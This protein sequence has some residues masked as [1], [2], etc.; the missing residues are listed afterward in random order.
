MFTFGNNGRFQ[1]LFRESV[2]FSN[3]EKKICL[4]YLSSKISY[5][6]KILA[7]Y[8]L[9]GWSYWRHVQNI[10]TNAKRR[11]LEI[12]AEYKFLTSNN[13]RIQFCRNS[14]VLYFLGIKSKIYQC[15]AQSELYGKVFPRSFQGHSFQKRFL[16]G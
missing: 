6:P 2:T 11:R 16:K 13:M 9:Y 8:A 4:C 12:L 15:P 14:K 5:I 7:T 10:S 3:F 1:T